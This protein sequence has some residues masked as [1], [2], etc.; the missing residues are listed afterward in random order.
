MRCGNFSGVVWR[1]TRDASEKRPIIR[2]RVSPPTI[3]EYVV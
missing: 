1:W 3:L 2:A